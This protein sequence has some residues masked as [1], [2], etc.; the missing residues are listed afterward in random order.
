MDRSRDH[1]NGDFYA[2]PHDSLSS[3]GHPHGPYHLAQH[4]KELL[5][6]TPAW[7]WSS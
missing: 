1:L 4:I 3:P 7:N 5:A 6:Q 2:L